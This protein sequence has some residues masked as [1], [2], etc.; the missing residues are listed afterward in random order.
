MIPYYDS[1]KEEEQMEV[2]QSI[3]LLYKQTFL[4]ER[5]YERKSE[6]LQYNKEFRV[7][8][9]HLEFIRSYFA[10][11]GIAVI[12]NSQMGV[13]YIQGEN[14]LGEKLPKMATLYLL[15][16][17]L[18]Y[19]E[20]MESVSTSINIYST[21][22]DI[23]EKLANYRLLKKQPAPTEVK[24]TIT[25]LKKYQIIE[26]LDTLEEFGGTSR[27]IIY[28]CI[29]VVLLGDDVRAL[30]ESFSEGEE[31]DDQSEI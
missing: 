24:K 2:T 3:Q 22:S 12:E 5:K 21:L 20:Q 30:L 16:L 15:A 29:N 26:H 7:C 4:L 10:V 23:H 8:D 11:G 1:L 17:K 28:P 14:L 6:R 13:I 25:L 9:K 18:I 31:D 27:M 19:D